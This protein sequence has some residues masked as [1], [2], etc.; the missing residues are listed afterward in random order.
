[1][2]WIFLNLVSVH[3]PS[4]FLSPPKPKIHA[5][6]ETNKGNTMVKFMAPSVS[7]EDVP[8]NLGT[9]YSYYSLIPTRY[10]Y[11]DARQMIRM[12]YRDKGRTI[13]ET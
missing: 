10:D 12:T 6:E 2:Q 11:N 3:P 8:I 9:I 4:T 7:S 1:M 5:R 13:G